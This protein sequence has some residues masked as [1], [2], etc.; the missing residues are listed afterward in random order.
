MKILPIISYGLIGIIDDLDNKKTFM[1]K[2]EILQ[3]YS[4]KKLLGLNPRSRAHIGYIYSDLCIIPIQYELKRLLY[5]RNMNK[6]NRKLVAK[7]SYIEIL[8]IYIDYIR[9][10]LLKYSDI[11]LYI[12]NKNWKLLNYENWIFIRNSNIM[13]KLRYDILGLNKYLL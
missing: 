7:K 2:I 10:D 1:N 12:E 3:R 11:K 6:E 5:L 13:M 4:I 8:N 9:I